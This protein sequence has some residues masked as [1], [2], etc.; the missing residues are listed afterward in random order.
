MSG[1]NMQVTRAEAQAPG[2]SRGRVS[3]SFDE[4]EGPLRH[5]IR[6]ET[7]SGAATKATEAAYTKVRVVDN[8]QDPGGA[9]TRNGS[10][11]NNRPKSGTSTRS[12]S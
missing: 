6:Q 1:T 11:T 7:M 9:I 2:Q 4:Q 5:K 8:S 3:K 12:V 10:G